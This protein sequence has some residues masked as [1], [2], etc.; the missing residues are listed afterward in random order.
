MKLCAAIVIVI[1][2]D[3]GARRDPPLQHIV[4]RLSS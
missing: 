2:G 3:P 4:S 1:A